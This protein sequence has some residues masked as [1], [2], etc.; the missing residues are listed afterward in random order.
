MKHTLLSTILPCCI[1]LASCNS[2]PAAPAPVTA[3]VPIVGTWRL[4]SGTTITKGVSSVTDY[5]KDVSMIKIINGT[6][7][8]FLKHD[9]N[10]PKDST[11]HFDAGGGSYTLS[12]DQYTE[13]LDYY[14]DR[15]WEGKTFQ[16]TVSISNDTLIQRGLEKVE[17]EGI[18]R[19][20]IERYVRT[21]K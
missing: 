17:K 10:S 18:D 4:V 15:N 3:S 2:R 7:F 6:H 12:G 14:S 5:A 13:H 11:N 16:F 9:L 19:E 1:L 20:I 8:A 21:V